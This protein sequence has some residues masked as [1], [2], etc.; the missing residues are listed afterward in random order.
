MKK[1]LNLSVAVFSLV[2][3]MSVVIGPSKARAGGV[4]L[5]INGKSPFASDPALVAEAGKVYVPY[6]SIATVAWSATDVY[7]CMANSSWG[8]AFPDY[9]HMPFS[10]SGFTTPPVISEQRYTMNCDGLHDASYYEANRGLTMSVLPSSPQ[11]PVPFTV[12]IT[13]NG[14]TPPGQGTLNK[15]EV[16]YGSN[17]TIAW[18]STGASSCVPEYGF[19]NKNGFTDSDSGGTGGFL[20]YPNK[21]KSGTYTTGPVTS[22]KSFSFMCNVDMNTYDWVDPHQTLEPN[23]GWGVSVVPPVA[24]LWATLTASPNP[25]PYGGTTTLSWD[26]NGDNSCY[27]ETAGLTLTG[28]PYTKETLKGSK[29]IGPITQ[30]TLYQLMCS[31]T[32]GYTVEPSVNVLVEQ[33]QPFS[34][35][36]SNNAGSGIYVQAGGSVSSS[37]TASLIS[38]TAKNVTL[39]VSVLPDGA[40]ASFTPNTT[41]IPTDDALL[42]ISNLPSA[43]SSYPITVTV[44]GTSGDITRT[45]SFQLKKESTNPTTT[46]GPTVSSSDALT[47]MILGQEAFNKAHETPTPVS[48]PAGY[49]NAQSFLDV[50]QSDPGIL[51]DMYFYGNKWWTAGNAAYPVVIGGQDTILQAHINPTNLRSP[52]SGEMST[53]LGGVVLRASAKVNGISI[54]TFGLNAATKIGPWAASLFAEAQGVN[55][56]NVGFRFDLNSIVTKKK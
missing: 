9:M 6:G 28:S 36:L 42:T 5:T 48:L 7:Q 56:Y 30:L 34:F 40:S 39:S 38:G 1:I 47:Q 50:L 26:T 51:G 55:S 20:P 43:T 32:G 10:N 23:G 22:P 44:T 33:Q 29:E 16:P 21:N 11:P 41:F 2:L 45:T 13:A 53:D 17:A 4:T 8:G 19:T 46:S 37:I 12:S 54:P 15:I 31:D 24:P 52:L 25:V 27:S 14:K 3:L 18:S 49:N 35:S